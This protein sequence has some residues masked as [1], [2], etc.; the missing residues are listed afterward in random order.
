M[1]LHQQ[2]VGVIQLLLHVQIACGGGHESVA[3]R[4]IELGVDVNAKASSD[5]NTEAQRN[6]NTAILSML[7]KHGAH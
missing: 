6:G 5:V 7:L 3:V 4:L 1:L 2:V